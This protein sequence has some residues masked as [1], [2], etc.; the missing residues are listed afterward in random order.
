MKKIISVILISIL[1]IATLSACGP[2][3]EVKP[4]VTLNVKVPALQ[5]APL[6][7]PEIND[8]YTFLQKATDLFKEQYEDANVT[9]NLVQY[10]KDREDREIPGS[11]DTSRATDVLYSEFFNMSTYIHSGRVVPLDDIISDEIRNDIDESYWANGMING[12]TY[13][14]PYLGMQNTLAYNKDLF[15][16]VG[17]DKYIV[18][19]DVVQSWTLDEWEE[20]LSTLAEKLP[21]NVFPMMMYAKNS[22]GDTHIMTLLR[23]RGSTFFDE[24]GRIKLNTPEGL[25]AIQWLMDSN[26]KGYFP[27]NAETLETDDCGVLFYNQQLAISL[28][29]IALDVALRKYGFDYGNVNFP[30]IDGKGLNTTFITGFEVFDNGDELK[31]KVAKDFVKFVYENEQCLDYSSAGI[32]CSNRVAEKFADQ[33][34]IEQKYMDN[35]SNGWNFTNNSPAWRDVRAVFYPNIADLLYGEMSA[36]EIATQIENT[37]NAAIENGYANSKLHE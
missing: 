4:N 25:A 35:R 1:T 20:I 31:L 27:T 9:I 28:N 33:M 23:S 19:E 37:C 12:K 21:E 6:T 7:D 3:E 17:L 5:M 32:T 15:R 26:K 14:I 24:S 2:K 10:T 36:E 18:D 34:Q 29:N 16:Q 22:I 30:S 8:A 11:Y 13:M